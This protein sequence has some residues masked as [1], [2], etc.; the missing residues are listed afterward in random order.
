MGTL[1]VADCMIKPVVKLDPNLLVIE[2]ATK[3]IK[4]KSTGAPVVNENEAVIG[5]LSEYDCLNVVVQVAY[6]NQRI[7]IVNDVMQTDVKSVSPNDSAID[8]APKMKGDQP[9]VYPVVDD[10]NRLVGVISRRLIL[11]KLCEIV[12]NNGI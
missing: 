4:N 12:N 11:Q 10:H 7:A 2:A 3:L 5:W 1:T 8:L 9:K 6:Y